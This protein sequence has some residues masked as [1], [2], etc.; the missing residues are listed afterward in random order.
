MFK[1]RYVVLITSNSVIMTQRSPQS[2]CDCVR[3]N[4]RNSSLITTSWPV[5]LCFNTPVNL[6]IQITTISIVFYITL[7]VRPICTMNFHA[8]SEMI[9]NTYFLKMLDFVL[10]TVR[11][12]ETL[13]SHTT[14]Q[15]I[16][17]N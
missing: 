14:L 2:G 8:R 11:N 4:L 1:R 9:C 16:G 13:G 12:L 5:P 7:S 6:G 15:F 10:R 17:K 3:D